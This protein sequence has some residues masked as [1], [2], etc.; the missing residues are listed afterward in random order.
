MSDRVLWRSQPL[1]NKREDYGWLMCQ[2]YRSTGYF[3]N[4]CAHKPKLSKVLA[5]PI[6]KINGKG[7]S[8]QAS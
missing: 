1:P 3:P 7:Y 8:R 6:A 2:H 5:P 4:F